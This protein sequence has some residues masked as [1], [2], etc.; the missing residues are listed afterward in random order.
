MEEVQLESLDAPTYLSY[1]EKNKKEENIQFQVGGPN[2][3]EYETEYHS[4]EAETTY[5][6][7]KRDV[8]KWKYF[9]AILTWINPIE[10]METISSSSTS[11]TVVNLNELQNT[12]SITQDGLIPAHSGLWHCAMYILTHSPSEFFIPKFYLQYPFSL[13]K[14]FFTVFES[15][16]SS[17][18][19]YLEKELTKS[20]LWAE[21]LSSRIVTA[22]L[23]EIKERIQGQALHLKLCQNNFFSKELV[24]EYEA[25]TSFEPISEF[26]SSQMNC[27][28]SSV[29]ENMLNDKKEEEDEKEERNEKYPKEE[30]TTIYVQME[31]EKKVK[32][33]SDPLKEYSKMIEYIIYHWLNNLFDTNGKKYINEFFVSYAQMIYSIKKQHIDHMHDILYQSILSRASIPLYSSPCIHRATLSLFPNFIS[34]KDLVSNLQI[35]SGGVLPNCFLNLKKKVEAKSLLL[36]SGRKRKH[37]C[38]TTTATSTTNDILCMCGKKYTFDNEKFGSPDD[39]AA[40]LDGIVLAGSAFVSVS[41]QSERRPEDIDLWILNNNYNKLLELIQIIWTFIESELHDQVFLIQYTNIYTLV[42]PK[43]KCRFQLIVTEE[44]NPC[45]LVRKF[46]FDHL[47]G[48]YNGMESGFLLPECYFSWKRKLITLPNYEFSSFRLEK[49]E[50]AG[51]HLDSMVMQSEKMVH[52]SPIPMV[53]EENPKDEDSD[54]L[55]MKSK[56]GLNPFSDEF[57]KL[58]KTH[59]LQTQPFR[60]IQTETEHPIQFS[61]H[62]RSQLG[63]LY[64]PENMSLMQIQYLYEKVFPNGTFYSDPKTI[65]KDLKHL[66]ENFHDFTF[67]KKI[68][69]EKEICFPSTFGFGFDYRFCLSSAQAIYLDLNLN[70]SN[71]IDEL[72]ELMQKLPSSLFDSELQITKS[73][74]KEDFFFIRFKTPIYCNMEGECHYVHIPFSESDLE[75]KETNKK[76][77]LKLLLCDKDSKIWF[78]L[79]EILLKRCNEELKNY[80][81]QLVTYDSRFKFRLPLLTLKPESKDN[82]I[83]YIKFDSSTQVNSYLSG[84]PQHVELFAPTPNHKR[85][86]NKKVLDKL[87]RSYLQIKLSLSFLFIN[88]KSHFNKTLPFVTSFETFAN[89]IELFHNF[90]HSKS[91]YPQLSSKVEFLVCSIK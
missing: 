5:I 68:K 27:S 79:Q 1:D 43:K 11:T 4:I 31:R 82:K 16:Q 80:S 36:G 47:R 66:T 3:Y 64:P 58:S 77:Y 20:N 49:A 2:W 22:E 41:N 56:Y 65:A 29:K 73:K 46:D 52:P 9:E 44:R 8:I 6:I 69:K 25:A 23:V 19:Y 34:Q 17:P 57:E 60:M 28:F 72:S 89:T 91:V 74:K 37:P 61:L 90:A 83:A 88:S 55:M 7:P 76:A 12:T 50:K 21:L 14:L 32:K 33:C 39:A 86:T 51:F 26:F 40:W 84:Y 71:I 15:W 85:K 35:L 30:K 38:S 59:D 24:K 10:K 75:A 81:T 53:V 63:W 42:Y 78:T 18:I 70:H 48:F 87:K 54:L 45:E 67:D 62:K 13:Q